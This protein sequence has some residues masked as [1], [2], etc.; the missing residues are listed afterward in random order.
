MIVEQMLPRENSAN[1]KRSFELA[2]LLLSEKWARGLESLVIARSISREAIEKFL[3][4]AM[5]DYCCQYIAANA[6]RDGA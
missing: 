2:A 4:Q 6:K 3:P 5:Y 1:W